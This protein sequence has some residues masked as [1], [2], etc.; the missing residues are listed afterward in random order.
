MVGRPIAQYYYGFLWSHFGFFPNYFAGTIPSRYYEGYPYGNAALTPDQQYVPNSYRLQTGDANFIRNAGYA[1]SLLATF[2]VALLV[3]VVMIQ[4]L[5]K[6]CGK[7]EIW[8]HR[9]ARQAFFAGI[10][11]V[12]MAIVYWAVAHLLYNQGRAFTKLSGEPSSHTNFRRGCSIAAIVF[13]SLYVLYAIIRWCFN[14]IGGLYTFKRIAV[15]VILAAST[16][17]TIAKSSRD[18]VIGNKAVVIALIATEL[19]F[20][21]LRFILESPYLRRQKF[22]ILAEAIAIIAAYLIMYFWNDTGVIS[23]YVSIVLFLFILLF[24]EDLIDVYNDSRDQFYEDYGGIVPGSTQK[25]V[26]KSN[27]KDWAKLSREQKRNENYWTRN[28]I[29][30]RKVNENDLRYN[31]HPPSTE[32]MRL[33]EGKDL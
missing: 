17:E 4:I 16:Y 9:I 2:L 1:F 7:F 10:E 8:Y 23:I 27:E 31:E 3:V 25:P 26:T 29:H 5:R 28:K 21:V 14:S 33:A 11:F 12:C 15:A 6:V 30:S 32:R 24:I 18:G 13:I 22:Y 20:M 19:I